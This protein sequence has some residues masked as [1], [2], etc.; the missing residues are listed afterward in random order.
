MEVLSIAV[1]ITT[2]QIVQ[3][4]TIV[5]ATVAKIMVPLEA[6]FV[7]VALPTTAVRLTTTVRLIMV[8]L[9]VPTLQARDLSVEVVHSIV[10]AVPLAEAAM[11][12]EVPLEVVL[13][14]ARAIMAAVHSVAEDS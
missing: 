4:I 5:L 6:V 11:V 3:T 2:E 10:E 12:H 7:A 8:S 13:P 1:Q 9:H 14:V